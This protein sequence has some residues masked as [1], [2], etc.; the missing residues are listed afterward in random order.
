MN[1]FTPGEVGGRGRLELTGAILGLELAVLVYLQAEATLQK[2][3]N[4]G[5]GTCLAALLGTAAGL[6]QG[7][8]LLDPSVLALLALAVSAELAAQRCALL[9]REF[10]FKGKCSQTLWCVRPF[11]G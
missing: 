4:L 8:G 1:C 10:E 6:G 9:K 11:G 5:E 3:K 2:L 7:K